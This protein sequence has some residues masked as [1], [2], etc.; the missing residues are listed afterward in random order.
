MERFFLHLRN[1]FRLKLNVD[2]SYTY[3]YNKLYIMCD[4]V[5]RERIEEEAGKFGVKIEKILTY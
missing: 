3:K 2:Y 1:E 5:F 4:E